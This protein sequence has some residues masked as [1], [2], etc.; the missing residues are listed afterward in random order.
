MANRLAN[1][2]CRVTVA[3]HLVSHRP[4]Y[5]SGLDVW[6]LEC[7]RLDSPTKELPPELETCISPLSTVTSDLGIKPRPPASAFRT[8][9][10]IE[11]TAI[12]SA[13]KNQADLLL[14]LI[15]SQVAS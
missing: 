11:P 13:R 3:V 9:L 8:T 12:L 7:L 2:A 10:A 6:R 15:K 4:Q 5:Q 1:I 14:R